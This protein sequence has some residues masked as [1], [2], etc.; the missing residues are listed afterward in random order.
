[1]ARVERAVR[2]HLARRT[3][4]SET[5]PVSALLDELADRGV[6]PALREELRQLLSQADFLR[7]APQLGD[8]ADEISRLRAKTRDVLGRV[9]P[10]RHA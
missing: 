4:A 8:Y 6:P 7:F 9:R 10:A 2:E 1:M 3:G 5:T